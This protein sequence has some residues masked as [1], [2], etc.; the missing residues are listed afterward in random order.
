V[1]VEQNLAATL[2]LAHRA[3]IINNGHVVHE[4][5]AAEIKADPQVLQ[6]WLGV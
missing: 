3:Y 5:P 1:L 6:R 2:A 4:G